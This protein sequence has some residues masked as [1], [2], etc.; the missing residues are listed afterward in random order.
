VLDDVLVPFKLLKPVPLEP[1]IPLRPDEFPN[2]LLIL[3]I[4]DVPV[5]AVA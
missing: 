5:D 3:I 1:L 4:A 2:P